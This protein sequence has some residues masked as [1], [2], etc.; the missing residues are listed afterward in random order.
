MQ[1]LSTLAFVFITITS[2]VNLILREWR[3]NAV[4]LALQYLAAFILVTLSW[5]VGMAVIKL[6]V[7]WMASA[8][9]A[10]TSLHQSQKDPTTDSVASLLFRGLA[11]LLVIM[12]IFILAPRLQESIFPNLDLVIVQGGLMLMGMSLMQLGTRAD[13]YLN[14]ISLL[15]LLTGFEIIHAALERSTLLTGM[16]AVVDL[17]LALAGVYFISQSSAAE[18]SE[19]KAP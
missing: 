3:I 6:I 15:S 4:A 9:I 17:G 19:E 18:G 12:I 5:P 14:I 1:I 11:G 13:P 7:G 16:L 8:A 10:L 2:M